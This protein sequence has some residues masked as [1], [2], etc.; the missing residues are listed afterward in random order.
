[1][2]FETE[3]FELWTVEISVVNQRISESKC[4]DFSCDNICAICVDIS[5]FWG[6]FVRLLLLATF[7]PHTKIKYQSTKLPNENRCLDRAVLY[8]PE[9]PI[10]CHYARPIN[11]TFVVG[12]CKDYDHCNRDLKPILHVKNATG[13]DTTPNTTKL[14]IKKK[15]R[16]RWAKEELNLLETA[17][18]FSVV[19]ASP[20]FWTF[21]FP[22]WRGLFCSFPWFLL[23][24]TL[25][26]VFFFPRLFVLKS[27]IPSPRLNIVPRQ[28]DADVTWL[29]VLILRLSSFSN[30]TDECMSSTVDCT[31]GNERT[32]PPWSF[33]CLGS[34]GLVGLP[35]WCGHL[36]DDPLQPLLDGDS[37]P[38]V[39]ACCH[40]DFCNAHPLINHT[41]SLLLTGFF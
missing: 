15:K 7:L 3:C 2:I 8:P 34:D 10:V 39:Y 36:N 33:S 40:R 4:F 12:C 26:S 28:T 25:S 21:H 6:W 32:D 9:N 35:L 24:I 19:P 1:M 23:A 14:L 37:N 11:D 5:F 41:S 18:S 27:D 30:T 16:K 31:L 29:R 20:T 17:N 38:Y 13:N 22:F